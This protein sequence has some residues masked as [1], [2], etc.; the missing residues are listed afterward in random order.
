MYIHVKNE[1]FAIEINF[2]QR[3]MMVEDLKNVC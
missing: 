3:Y 1:S 2:H